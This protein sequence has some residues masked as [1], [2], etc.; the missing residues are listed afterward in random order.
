MKPSINQV[1]IPTSNTTFDVTDASISGDWKG[2][3]I[4]GGN[5]TANGT[6][7]A[8]A[9]MFIGATDGSRNVSWVGTIADAT[10]GAVAI[11]RISSTYCIQRMAGT[12]LVVAGAL[13]S[14]QSGGPRFALSSNDATAHLINV[15]SF[16]GTDFEF[17]CSSVQFTSTDTTK[18]FAHNLSG[19]PDWV[20]IIVANG[21]T[22]FDSNS[23][24][25]PSMGFW[26]GTNSVGWGATHNTSSNPT[27]VAARMVS[28]DVGHF[29]STSPADFTSFS[30]S[31]VGAANLTVNKGAAGSTAASVMI[32]AGRHTV[33]TAAA[34][35]SINTMPTVTGVNTVNSG[36]AVKPQMWISFNSRLTA[37]TFSGNSDTAGSFGVGMAVNNLGTT[38]QASVACTTKQGVATSVAK[39]YTS[40]TAAGLVLDNTGAVQGSTTVNAWQSGGVQENV[41]TAPASALERINL[42]FGI[43]ST[44]NVAL[45]FAGIG[46]QKFRTRR[47]YSIF[48][49][50]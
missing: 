32:M 31:S 1:A 26:D 10:A 7:T 20:W 49:P 24:F 38:Q 47:H 27:V 33:G 19:V 16:A 11:E 41:G 35:A 4:I 48:I 18:T 42:A 22:A 29:I 3:I 21:T 34:L 13:N 9:G 2:S 8:G 50:R 39:S 14:I 43:S 25:V 15:L 23:G 44:A 30:L 46:Q 6:N 17:G 45:P 28:G 5:P 36:M 40:A 37:T 12:S